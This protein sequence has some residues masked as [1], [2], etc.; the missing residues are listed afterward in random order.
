MGINQVVI[1]L[2]SLAGRMALMGFAAEA[3][4]AQRQ[5]AAGVAKRRD[6]FLATVEAI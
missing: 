6:G 5:R 4:G 1:R 2:G 3:F